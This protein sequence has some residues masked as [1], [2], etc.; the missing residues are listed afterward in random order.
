VVANYTTVFDSAAVLG[1]QDVIVAYIN[2]TAIEQLSQSSLVI[3]NQT[4][5]VN[6]TGLAQSMREELGTQRTY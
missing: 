4:Y 2:D 6:S 5:N 1:Y 3:G